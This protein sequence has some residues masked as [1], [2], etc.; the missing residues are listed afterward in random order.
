MSS[1]KQVNRAPTSKEPPRL[2]SGPAQSRQAPVSRDRI[3][4]LIAGG[5]RLYREGLRLILSADNAIGIIGE[6]ARAPDTLDLI[7]TL[8][9]DVVLLD[10][11]MCEGDDL[12]L[13]R[14]IKLRS[15]PTKVLMLALAGQETLIFTALKAGVTGCVLKDVSGADV[16]KAVQ[17][18]QHGEAWLSRKLI[19]R[20]LEAESSARHEIGKHDART[21]EVLTGR[22]QEVIR[23]LTSGGTNKDI[24]QTL[25][26]S[27][28]TV[29]THLNNI[30]RKLN[31]TR[32]LELALYAIRQGLR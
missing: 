17:T 19:A 25:D 22:E 8:K 4:V 24:A 11:T 12:G 20:F 7:S 2:S 10:I 26:I 18:V 6:A 32:R 30:F 29:K 1:P 16:I 14:M 13:I 21:S 3:R 23:A 28:K 15:P 27:E 31:V 9:P 5:P